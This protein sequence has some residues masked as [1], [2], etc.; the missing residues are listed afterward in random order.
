MNEQSAYLVQAI[1][2]P[3]ILITIGVLF[4]FDRFTDFR[5]SQTWP[6]LLIVVGVL[7]LV[8][9]PRRRNRDYYPQPVGMPADA[10]Q[11]GTVDDHPAQEVPSPRYADS[12]YSH[13]PKTD[14]GPEKRS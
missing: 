13:S 6:V 3:L 1:R 5:F 10:P 12:R 8:G 4:A 9:G 11:R 14:Q 7:R 2:G